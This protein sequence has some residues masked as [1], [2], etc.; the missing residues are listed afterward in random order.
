M[1]SS[2]RTTRRSFIRN[3]GVAAGTI[4]VASLI[5]PAS[6]AQALAAGGSE[7][8]A[9]RRAT[10]AA[11]VDAV[12]AAGGRPVTE[13]DPA[14]AAD[15]FASWYGEAADFIKE[16]VEGTL[17]TLEEALP[18]GFSKGSSNARVKVL[19]AWLHGGHGKTP[20][21]TRQASI[22]VSALSFAVVPFRDGLDEP[23]LPLL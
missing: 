20:R 3:G 7:F 6:L 13:G 2:S 15:K 16:S 8:T 9:Q 4:G 1:E 11:L 21:G 12:G 14:G 18:N 19:R 17:D 10:Y 22:A 5:G 23:L